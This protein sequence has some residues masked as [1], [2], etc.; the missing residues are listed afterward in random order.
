MSYT[1]LLFEENL[2]EVSSHFNT[3]ELLDDFGN[4][5]NLN[6]ALLLNEENQSETSSY[7]ETNEFD[8]DNNLSSEEL[9][10]T[11]SAINPFVGQS[12]DIWDDA[13]SFLKRYGLQKGF[14]I[15][16]RRINAPIE[17]GI[18]TTRYI[19][20]ECSYAGSY[21]PKKRLDP[22]QQ[23]NRMAKA[24]GCKWHVNGNLAKSATK[25]VFTTV[26]DCHNHLL[27]PSPSIML[28]QYRRLD[29][30]MIQFVD[31]CVT[32]RT[33]GARN[34][35]RLLQGKF[36]NKKIHTKN[37]YN[38]IQ[39]SKKKL[40]TRIE[41]D[42]SDLLRFLYNKKCENS[43]WFIEAKFDGPDRRLCNIIWISPE[44]LQIWTRYHD[45]IFVDTTSRTNR[46]NMVACFF[47]AIDNV[48][49]T[50]LVA[51]A[52]LEDETEEA[53]IWALQMI[54]KATDHL[55]PRVIFT[56]S[57]FALQ[58]AI[59]A[60]FPNSLH[61]LCLF[62]INLNLK[63]NLQPKFT[64]DEFYSFKKDFYMCR[65]TLVSHIFEERW[66]ELKLK[67]PIAV[68]YLNRQLDT[69]K[70]KWAACYIQT[71]FTAGANSTQRIESLNNKIHS[72]VNSQT[73]LLTLV[74]EI[75]QLLSNEAQYIQAAEYQQEIPMIGLA[76]VSQTYFQSI[77]I[78]VREFLLPSLVTLITKQMQE[79][80][81]Y[82]AIKIDL[83][84]ISTITEVIL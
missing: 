76:T 19:G 61:C 6:N 66:A 9:E 26:V 4:N 38:A 74:E 17:N 5:N 23:R 22:Q 3:D 43:L 48:N 56:D 20:W 71:Q 40:Q 39:H 67:Y 79:C 60:E 21:E 28:S 84:N 24:T 78:T 14:G 65:N 16:R 31:F 41:H 80:F 30:E 53:F 12:F 32:H 46:Y 55:Y 36:P 58:N 52:L 42:A 75:Q 68:S 29:N 49:R 13:E 47:A 37:L 7:F 11:E 77:D 34:I 1:Q 27:A 57:D 54:N 82:D 8:S 72:C 50:R 51:T 59:T 62:H 2:S 25:I 35:T 45:I 15:H 69:F 81:F 63:K 64:K 44:Q 18:K 83:Q 10:S 73:S 33:T 70:H